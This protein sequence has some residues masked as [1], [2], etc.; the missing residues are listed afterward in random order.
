MEAIDQFIEKAIIDDVFPGAS[1]LVAQKGKILFNKI[2][3]FAQKIPT[4]RKMLPGTLFDIASLTKPICTATLYMLAVQEKACALSDTLSH[5]YPQTSSQISLHHLLNH[6][7]GL[8]SWKP[9]YQELLKEAPG[10]VADSKGKEWL[11]SKI[12]R[13]TKSASPP[14]KMFYSDLGYI[15]L[16]DILEKLYNQPLHKL[17]HEKISLNFGLLKTF[18]NP[19][20]RGEQA[21]DKNV[22]HYAA[23]DQCPWREKVLCGEVMDD[24]AYVM[25]G[26]AGHAG[27]FSDASDCFAWLL[28]LSKA[29]KGTSELITKNT[30]NLFCGMPKN[31]D[32]KIPFFTLGFDT[33]L[34]FSSSGQY[35][36]SSSLGH[37]GY[38][39]TSFWWDLE[40]EVMIIFLTNRVHPSR[41]NERIKEFRPRIHDLIWESLIK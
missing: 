18:F 20:S 15:L 24:H 41:D 38:S 26:V 6:T 12:L 35:F 4:E 17:F 23:T 10:W 8:P 30:F 28:E 34:F 1:L 25:G 21:V 2:Y 9:Y 36:S 16:G 39:G 11:V 19:I 40:K 13:E 33:P 29:K 37:L 32:R 7:S 22:K 27:L 31:R 14:A 3:G 5:F